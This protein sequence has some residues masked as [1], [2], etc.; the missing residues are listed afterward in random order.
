MK[1]IYSLIAIFFSIT[2]LFYA[3]NATYPEFSASLIPF[4]LPLKPFLPKFF[5][6]SKLHFT[7]LIFLAILYTYLLSSLIILCQATKGKLRKF[8]STYYG[9]TL[10]FCTVFTSIF[11]LK[12]LSAHFFN[13]E[14]PSKLHEL[15][16]SLF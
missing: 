14:A 8:M 15:L 3:L 11:L 1:Y 13:A 4:L 9:G 16:P 10:T 6:L 12:L 5:P 2:L 7:Q